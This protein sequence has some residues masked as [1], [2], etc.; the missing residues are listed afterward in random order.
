LRA[1]GIGPGDEVI[2]PAY[3]FIGSWLAVTHAG[4]TPIGVDVEPATYNL[5]PTALPQALS[6]RTAAIMPV[7][8][9]GEPAAMDA[10][11]EFAEA[12]NLFLL[13]DAAQAHGARF[14]GRR[15]GSLGDAAGFSFYPTKNLGAIGDAGAIVTDDDD[16]AGRA[17]L[18]R[19]YGSRSRYETE[20]AGFNS[21]LAEV[22]AAA[23]RAFLPHLD[24]HN[25]DRAEL[26]ARYADELAAVEAIEVPVPID[27]AEPVWHLYIVGLEERN[28]CQT[29]LADRGI[30]TLI[31]Y[32]VLPHL[33]SVY[34]FPPGSF[35]VAERL[36]SRALSLPM[37]PFLGAAD[38]DDVVGALLDLTDG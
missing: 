22:Q 9:R 34:G 4:A 26:A 10:L 37:H 25:A 1:A 11:R 7:H 38:C 27:G 33:S 15:A 23:L 24:R 29:A 21:R 32:P 6:D 5:D 8:L 3:T 19:N 31:H 20:E 36:A 2:V 16:L 12:H 18:L 14:A 13:E 17:R 28:R 30:E 35:P